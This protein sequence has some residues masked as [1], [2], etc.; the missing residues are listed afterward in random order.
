MKAILAILGGDGE[1][2]MAISKE[3]D[4]KYRHEKANIHF[5]SLT[6]TRMV[7]TFASDCR[8]W[9]NGRQRCERK[10][11]KLSKEKKSD[12]FKGKSRNEL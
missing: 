12:L 1:G 10:V 5:S 3:D 6:K 8:Y 4:N 9:C 7:N 2:C 11:V